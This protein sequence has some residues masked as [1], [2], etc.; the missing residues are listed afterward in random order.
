[1]KQIRILCKD[2]L[3]SL[4]RTCRYERRG[5]TKSLIC[6]LIYGSVTPI[7]VHI[8]GKNSQA[9]WSNYGT[10]SWRY[11]Q[12]GYMYSD[13]SWPVFGC[14]LRA[15][16]LLKPCAAW[17]TRWEASQENWDLGRRDGASSLRRSS[18]NL[19]RR[20]ILTGPLTLLLL[21]HWFFSLKRA[22]LSSWR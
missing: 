5:A 6:V 12:L 20:E 13:L 10:H 3:S 8:N 16:G 19:I 4:H 9:G 7:A 2:N 1:M 15:N 21:L 17:K 18:W 14:D 22:V 11:S